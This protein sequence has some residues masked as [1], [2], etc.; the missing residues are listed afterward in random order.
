MSKKKIE[1]TKEDLE[2]WLTALRSGLF[3]QTVGRLYSGK[4]YCCLGVYFK[5]HGEKVPKCAVDDG[6][7]NLKYYE[8]IGNLVGIGLTSKLIDLNDDKVPFNKI[9]DVIEEEFKDVLCH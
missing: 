9:A 1:I 3:K 7:E 8:R 6:T 2:I 4:G 5:A